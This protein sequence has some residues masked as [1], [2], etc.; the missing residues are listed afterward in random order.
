MKKFLSILLVFSIMVTM[1]IPSLAATTIST[2]AAHL[3][4]LGFSQEFLESITDEDVNYLYE[5]SQAYT[6]R[7]EGETSAFLYTDDVSTSG[8]IPRA[9]MKLNVYPISTLNRDG[10]TYKEIDI[11]ITYD[12]TTGHPAMRREDGVSVNW[13][14]SLFYTSESTFK[15][16]DR[17]YFIDTLIDSKTTPD[18]SALAQGGLGYN[19]NFPRVG[20]GEDDLQL[21]YTFSGTA[22]FTLYPTDT[23]YAGNN[24]GTSINVEYCHS[25]TPIAGSVQFGYK[26]V[27]VSISPPLMYDS[28]ASNCVIK[29]GEYADV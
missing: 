17:A 18:A 26:G 27:S 16:T 12:W 9:D 10:Y 8:T 5:K 7:Y 13:D 3:Q 21:K 4:E 19:I 22:S 20:M 24:K 14:A 2:Q 25:K 11:Y 1:I 29:Y 28:V 23:M 15:S 6:L